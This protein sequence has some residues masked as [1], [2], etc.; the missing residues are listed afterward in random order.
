MSGFRG[1]R[2]HALCALATLAGA[3]GSSHA[4]DAPPLRYIA[5]GTGDRFGSYVLA[6]LERVRQRRGLRFQAVPP[7]QITQRRL[8][9]EVSRRGG[10]ADLMWGMSNAQRR[11]ELRCLEPRLD[12]GLIGCRLLVVRVDDLARWPAS[13]ATRVLQ[14]RRAGQGL[15]WPDVDILRD[16]G[17]RVDTAGGTL[18]L[19][20]MLQRGHIDYFPRSALEVL[21][22]LETLDSPDLTIAPGLMLRYPAGNHIFAGRHPQ[23]QVDALEE[24]LALLARSGEMKRLFDAAFDPV[25]RPLAL[26]GRRSITLHNRRDG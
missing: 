11:S 24:Q 18:A 14:A 15:H 5:P 25:L 19:Y 22:E 2:R 17:F 10:V 16:N 21:E 26:A 13:L 12:E 7:M 4:D 3:A 1:D 20:E 9:L 6:L 8:E 23:P